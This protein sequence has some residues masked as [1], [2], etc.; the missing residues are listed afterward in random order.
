MRE[1]KT[2]DVFKMSRILKKLDIKADFDIDAGDEKWDEKVGMAMLVKIAENIHLA[3]KE[4]NDFLGDLIGKTADEFAE[5]TFK[6]ARQVIDEF[7]KLDGVMDFFKLAGSS[8][9]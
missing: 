2:K 3:E 1:L 8:M 6:E 5:L 7:K 9:K 4:V